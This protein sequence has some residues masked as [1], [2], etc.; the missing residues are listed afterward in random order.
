MQEAILYSRL[1]G[2]TVQCALCAH[3]CVIHDGKTGIC[4]VRRNTKGVLYSLVYGQVAAAHIDPIEKKPLFHFLPGTSSFSISTVGCNFRCDFCQN[5]E[6]SQAA[7]ALTT[8]KAETIS[9]ETIVK[10]AQAHQAPSISYTYTEPTIYFEYALDTMKLARKAGIKNV[11]VTNGFMTPECLAEAQ[12]YLDAANVDLKSFSDDF[13][14]KVCGG[15]LAPVLDSIRLMHQ[16]KIWVEVTTLVI[17]GMNDSRKELQGIAHFLA[18]VDASIPWH[19]SKFF[20]GY[21]MASAQAT[22]LAKLQEAHA[23]GKETGLR[24]V[25][26]GNIAQEENTYCYHCHGLLIKRSGFAVHENKIK[27]SAC[28]QCGS[29]IDGVGL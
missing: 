26:M 27:N 17:P 2:A 21:K 4:G 12:P 16:Y 13:Y 18:G 7:E 15:R 9:P 20:P 23:I 5:W 29:I 3:R 8:V 22:P 10:Q 1:D 11:F 19:I 25:Y 24:Y 6:I 28:P 14:A